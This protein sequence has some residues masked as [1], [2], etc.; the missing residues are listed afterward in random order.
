MNRSAEDLKIGGL[1]RTQNK[2]SN[3]RDRLIE[4]IIHNF[5]SSVLSEEEKPAL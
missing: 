5:S 1:K 4:K 3:I 2:I